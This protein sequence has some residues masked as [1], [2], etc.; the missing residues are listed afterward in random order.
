MRSG[1]FPDWSLPNS[2]LRQH[3]GLPYGHLMVEQVP[4]RI[5]PDRSSELDRAAV[6]A[7]SSP[8]LASKGSDQLKLRR[9][10]LARV[11]G[12]VVGPSSVWQ[13]RGTVE[14]AAVCRSG[15]AFTL[16]ELLVVIAIIAILA[17]MLLPTLGRAKSQAIRTTCI[18]NQKQIGIAYKLYVDDNRGNYPVHTGWADFGGKRATNYPSIDGYGSRTAETNRP[19]NKYTGAVTVFHCPAD[20]GDSLANE[21]FGQKYSSAWEGWGN[22]YI[23]MWSI[24]YSRSKK[25]TDIPSGKPIR[26]EE[27][28]LRATTKIIQGDW[29]WHSNRNTSDRQNLWHNFKGKRVEV[30]LYGDMHVANSR[31]PASSVQSDP[32]FWSR[33]PDP[34]FDWW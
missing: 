23:G 33:P 32:G 6:A 5:E 28:A 3:A 27:V 8:I 21:A 14:I 7:T 29:V 16:I 31:F 2:A 34:T 12:L 15:M 17:G 4:R 22:S 10:S 20:R 30:M 18:S 1:S 26:E 13:F 9:D 25:V 24:D 11:N 19:L